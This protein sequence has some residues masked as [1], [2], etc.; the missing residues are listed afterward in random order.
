VVASTTSIPLEVSTGVRFGGV[1]GLYVAG[2]LAWTTG[3]SSVVMALDSALTITNMNTPI[4]TAKM[5]AD[6]TNDP[7]AI[8]L[9]GLAGV[10]IHTRHVRVFVQAAESSSEVSVALGLRAVR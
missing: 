9:H 7:R 10:E 2:G 5:T 6:A 3:S 4:G 1:L 8:T